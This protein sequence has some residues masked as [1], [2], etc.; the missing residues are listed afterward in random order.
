M[1]FVFWPWDVPTSHGWTTTTTTTMPIWRVLMTT[2]T[3]TTCTTSPGRRPHIAIGSRIPPG[4]VRKN[5]RRTTWPLVPAAGATSHPMDDDHDDDDDD[6]QVK[7]EALGNNNNNDDDDDYTVATSTTIQP[8]ASGRL[9]QFVSRAT[10]GFPVYVATMS[11]LGLFYPSSMQWVNRGPLVTFLLA[12]VM[13]ASG[14]A[15]QPHDFAQVLSK[16]WSSVPLGVACQFGIMPLTAYAVGRAL[17]LPLQGTTVA[18][19]TSSLGSSLF[20]GLCLV[21]CSPGGTA[22]NLVTLIAQANLALSVVLTACSTL[23]AVIATPLLVQ[24]LVQSQVQ[25]SA[26]LLCLGTARV[27]LGPVL[28]GMMVKARA[29]KVSQRLGRFTPLASAFMTSFI[30]GGVMAQSSHLLWSS[31]STTTAATTST[32][33]SGLWLLPR[34]VAAV[35]MLHG[36]GFVLGYFVPRRGF[37]K[38]RDTCR[39]MSIEVGMQNSALAIVLARSM[40]APPIAQLVGALSSSAHPCLGSLLAVLWRLQEAAAGGRSDSTTVTATATSSKKPSM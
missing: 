20:L 25:V 14:L 9:D 5:R 36:T 12:S 38:S 23:L 39:T 13:C 28:V 16:N 29:P 27:I 15:L 31:T 32:L 1:G 8:E 35:L 3:T 40:G 21:G 17:F 22:S 37:G 30:A 2:T 19:T 18:G 26:R 10:L 4:S 33:S 6:A 11:L 7:L 24:W 34:I